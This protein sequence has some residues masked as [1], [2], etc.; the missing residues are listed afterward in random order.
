MPKTDY[1]NFSDIN[2]LQRRIMIVVND[3]V[4]IEKTPIPLSEIMKSMDDQGVKDFTT[5]KAIQVL[6]KKGYIRRAI[7]ISNKRSYV[8]LKGL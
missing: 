1:V 2:D 3:W 5:I 8:M 4:H 6:L 7:I